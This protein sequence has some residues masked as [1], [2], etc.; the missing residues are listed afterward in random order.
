MI[1]IKRL[2][3]KALSMLLALVIIATTFFIFDPDLLRVESDAYANVET[4]QQ[5]TPLSAQT[6]YASETIYLKPGTNNFQYITNYDKNTGNVSSTLETTGQLYFKNDDA[7]EVA[8]AVNKLY[9]KG[10]DTNVAVNTLVMGSTTVAAYANATNATDSSIES[11]FNAATKIAT[12]SNGTMAYT[13]S[14]GSFSAHTDKTVDG[15]YFIEWIF[16]YKIDDIY[17]Y[18]FAYTGIYSTPLGMAGITYAVKKDDGSNNGEQDGMGFITGAMAYGGGNAKAAFTS[19]EVINVSGGI[20]S[21]TVFTNPLI[22]FNGY[23]GDNA[24][25]GNYTIPGNKDVSTAY[26]NTT[27]FPDKANGG[28]VRTS[29]R[30]YDGDVYYK[31]TGWSDYGSYA[32][33]TPEGSGNENLQNTNTTGVAYIVADISRF[34]NYN[35]LPYFKAGWA[36]FTY[37]YHGTGN[38]LSSMT[39]FDANAN[40]EV[41]GYSVNVNTGD[42]EDG[43]EDGKSFVRGLYA[44]NGAIPSSAT[45]YTLRINSHNG[46]KGMWTASVDAYLHVGFYTQPVNKRTIRQQYQGAL[47]SLCDYYNLINYAKITT[48]SYTSLFDSIKSAGEKICDPTATEVSADPT[49]QSNIKDYSDAIANSFGSDLYFYVPEAIYTRP[50]GSYGSNAVHS[51]ALFVNNVPTAN[52]P[53]QYTLQTG[54]V[55]Y[56]VVYF[57]YNDAQDIKVSYTIEESN[58][59]GDSSVTF[60]D[61]TGGSNSVTLYNASGSYSYGSS[62][63]T[64]YI[65]GCSVPLDGSETGCWIKW[66]VEYYDTMEGRSKNITARTYV[67]RT[68]YLPVAAGTEASAKNVSTWTYVGVQVWF[69][70]IHG[71]TSGTGGGDKRY[72][73]TNED[74]RFMPYS[75]SVSSLGSSFGDLYRYALSDFWQASSDN[76]YSPYDWSTDTADKEPAVYPSRFGTNFTVYDVEKTGAGTTRRSVTAHAISPTG[77]IAV[78][79]SRYTVGLSQIPGFSVGMHMT[80]NKRSDDGDWYLDDMT[81]KTLDGAGTWG[82][83]ENIRDSYWNNRGTQIVGGTRKNSCGVVYNGKAEGFFKFT[84]GSTTYQVKGILD[85]DNGNREPMSVASAQLNVTLYDKSALRTAVQYAISMGKDLDSKVF[86]TSHTQWTDYQDFLTAA[87]KA[88]TMVDGTY[89]YDQSGLNKLATDLTNAVNALLETEYYEDTNGDGTIGEG[90][91]TRW[92]SEARLWGTLTVKHVLYDP[93][94]PTLGTTALNAVQITDADGNVTSTT[95]VETK[96]YFYG[97]NIYSAYN[98]TPGYNYFGYY[99]SEEGKAW[100]YSSGS[101]PDLSILQ[102]DIAAQDTYGLSGSNTDQY[103]VGSSN[104]TYTYVYTAAES[105]LYL[106]LGD[107]DHAFQNAENLVRL[108]TATVYGIYDKPF[109]DDGTVGG[110][111]SVIVTD[112]TTDEFTFSTDIQGTNE[113]TP[114]GKMENK[115]TFDSGWHNVSTDKMWEVDTKRGSIRITDNTSTASADVNSVHKQLI[116]ITAGHK[117]IVTYDYYNHSSTSKIQTHIFLYNSTNTTSIK[118][119]S[120][121]TSSY[122]AFVGQ[123]SFPFSKGSVYTTTSAKSGTLIFEFTAPADY[124][125][126]A[127]R[128]GTS[129]SG[130]D[131]T[132]S[133]IQV[134]DMSDYVNHQKAEMNDI[135]F[136]NAATGLVP[137]K[138]YTVSFESPLTYDVRRWYYFDMDGNSIADASDITD[139][140]EWSHDQGTIQ[141]FI[142]TTS[143]GDDGWLTEYTVPVKV[144]TDLSSGGT[145][146]TFEMPAGCYNIN[147]GFCVT[148]NTPLSGTVTNVR[149]VEGDFVQ[150]GK[151]LQTVSIENGAGAVGEPTWMGYTF[152]GWTE[153][154]APFDGTLSSDISTHTHSFTYGIDSDTILANWEA[155]LYDVHFD[156]EIDVDQGIYFIQEGDSAELNTDTNTVTLTHSADTAYYKNSDAV[157]FKAGH[158]YRIS[159]DYNVT[160]GAITSLRFDLLEGVD[161]KKARYTFNTT[162]TS[163]TVSQTFTNTEGA[164]FDAELFIVSNASAG[165][166]VEFSDVYIQDITRNGFA[167]TT[168]S[169]PYLESDNSVIHTLNLSYRSTL[170][171]SYELG[172]TEDTKAVLPIMDSENFDFAGWYYDEAC[173]QAVSLDY[174]IPYTSTRFYSKWTTSAVFDTMGGSYRNSAKAPQDQTGLPLSGSSVK[175]A[176]YVPYKEGYNFAG[177]KAVSGD[178]SVNGNIYWPNDTVS[179]KCNVSFEAQW[180]AAEEIVFEGNYQFSTSYPGEVHYFSFNNPRKT[181]V[182]WA[183]YENST[184]VVNYYNIG[185]EQGTHEGYETNVTSYGLTYNV[186]GLGTYDAGQS[187]FGVAAYND[188]ETL[189]AIFTVRERF[190]NYSFDPAGGSLA[191]S[192]TVIGYVSADTTLPTPTR[193]GYTFTGWKNTSRDEVYTNN[194][195]PAE[196]NDAI[197]AGITATTSTNITLVAQWSINSYNM[198]AYAYSNKADTFYQSENSYSNNTVGGTVL[199]SNGEEGAVSTGENVFETNAVFTAT[200]ATGYEFKGW[201]TKLTTSEDGIVTLEDTDRVVDAGASYVRQVGAEDFTLYAKFSIKIY[202]W[203]ISAYHDT[204]ETPNSYVQGTIGGTALVGTADAPLESS[205]NAQAVHGEEITLYAKAQ[206]GYKFNGWYSTAA[207]V[208]SGSA[209]I[210]AGQCIQD[211]SGRYKYTITVDANKTY[212]AK[213]TVQKMTLTLNEN[214]DTTVNKGTY[215]QYAGSTVVLRNPTRTGHTLLGWTLV[216]DPSGDANG[217]FTDNGN[218]TITYTFGGGNDRI[219]A[220]WAISDYQVV[221]KP[222]GGT[223][224]A[225]SYQTAKGTMAPS[226]YTIN[227]VTEQ[228]TI[229]AA[230]QTAI[231]LQ[232]PTKAGYSFDGWE[233]TGNKGVFTVGDPAVYNVEA[234]DNSTVISAKWEVNSHPMYIQAYGNSASTDNYYVENVGGKVMFDG[235][236]LTTSTSDTVNYGD[237]RTI[238][239]VADTGYSFKGWTT[240]LPN[241]V[242][243]ANVVSS[244]ATYTTPGMGDGEITYYALF[245][246]NSYTVTATASYNSADADNV[247]VEGE[248]GGVVAG[249]GKVNY[250]SNAVL[251][252]AAKTGYDFVGWYS[253]LEGETAIYSSAT[254]SFAVTEDVTV[255]AKFAIKKYN[256]KAT[257]MANRVDDDTVYLE[258]NICGDISGQGDFYYGTTTTL[259]AAPRSGYEFLGWYSNVSLGE[260]AFITADYSVDVT[261]A[262][263]RVYNIWAKFAMLKFDVSISAA[264]VDNEDNITVSDIGGKVGFSIDTLT[265]TASSEYYTDATFRVY[266]Q[267]KV[268]YLLEGWYSD[269]TLETPA[270]GIHAGIGEAEGETG[271]YYQDFV[272]KG[273]V[274]NLYAKFK[275]STS[276]LN[277]IALSN[278]GADPTLYNTDNG[279]GTVEILEGTYTSNIVDRGAMITANVTYGMTATIRATAATGYTFEGWYS[280]PTFASGTLISDKGQ[281]E[282]PATVDAEHSYYAKFEIGRFIVTFDAMGG[283]LTNATADVYYGMELSLNGYTPTKTGFQFMGWDLSSTATSGYL[284]S[285]D[286]PTINSWYITNQGAEVTLYAIWSQQAYSIDLRTAYYDSAYNGY[287]FG[288]VG[289]TAKVI[290]AT[291]GVTTDDGTVLI[292]E[293]AGVSQFIEITPATGYKLEQWR[294]R[295]NPNGTDWPENPNIS[296]WSQ[297]LGETG[298]PACSIDVIV[299]F[300]LNDFDMEFYAYNNSAKAPTVFTNSATGGTVKIGENGSNGSKAEQHDVL[301]KNKVTAIATASAGYTFGGWYAYTTLDE[302]GAFTLDALTTP[303]ETG[304]SFTV[305]ADD[306]LSDVSRYNNNNYIAVFTINQYTATASVRTYVDGEDLVLTDPETYDDGGR[307]MN[308]GGNVGIGL[309]NVDEEMTWTE[310]VGG[311]EQS[312]TVYY[313]EKVYYKAKAETGY[314]FA[315]WYGTRGATYYGDNLVDEFNETYTRSQPARDT[316]LEAKFFP[317]TFTLRYDENGGAPGNP[318]EIR[319]TF[320][321]EFKYNESSNPTWTGHTFLGWADSPNGEVNSAYVG[322]IIADTISAWFVSEQ[323]QSTGMY[324]VYAV[325]EE[326]KVTVTLD[327]EKGDVATGDSKVDINQGDALPEIETPIY[328]GFVFGGYYTERGGQGEQRYDENGQSTYIWNTDDGTLYAY[329]K[330]PVLEDVE[331]NNGKWTYVYAADTGTY[332]VELSE[333]VTTRADI[334]AN[335]P[336]DAKWVSSIDTVNTSFIETQTER[337]EGINLNHYDQVALTN[338][339]NSVKD[340]DTQDELNTLNQPTVNQYVATMATSMDLDYADNR[341]SESVKPTVTI[342]ETSQKVNTIKSETD[343][344][345]QE[346]A[347]FQYEIPTS[348]DAASY[349]FAGKYSYTED[350]AVDYYIYTSSAN[351]VIA[352]EIGDGTVGTNASNNTAS[353]PTSATVTDN[354]AAFSYVENSGNAY[355]ESAVKATDDTSKAWFNAY[356]SAGIGTAHDYNAKTVI[357]LTPEFSSSGVRNEIVYTVKPSDDAYVVNEGIQENGA[358]LG[359]NAVSGFSSYSYSMTEDSEINIC[360]CY[361]NSMNG[362]SDEGT[363]D[364]S[365]DYMQMYIDQVDYDKYLNQMHL[366]RTSGGAS[367]WEL[368]SAG[369]SIYPVDDATYPYGTTGHILGSFMYV[370]DE[371]TNSVAASQAAA[372]NY[373]DAKNTIIQ[374]I[375]EDVVKAKSAIMSRNDSGNI[376]ST[377]TGLG[378]AQITGWSTNFYP[379]QGSYVY[380]HLVDRW[381]NV[382]NKVW[383]CN[384]VDPN[385]ST[386]SLD[387]EGAYKVL[388]TGGSNIDYITLDGANVTFNLD[389]TSTYE[390]GVLTTTGN[391]LTLSTGEANTTYNL[392]VVDNATNT[393][394]QAVTTDSNGMIVLNVEDSAI[395]VN[396]GAYTFTLNGETVNLYAGEPSVVR[397]ASVASAALVTDYITFTVKTA[398]DAIKVQVI[399][400]NSTWTYDINHSKINVVKNDDG[401]LT[402]TIPIKA[403]TVG[404]HVYSVRGKTAAGWEEVKFDNLI[405]KV[406]SDN[407]ASATALQSVNNVEVDAGERP[408]VKARTCVG[409]EKLQIVYADGSTITYNRTDDI[410]ISTI[411]GVETWLLSASAYSIPGSYEVSVVA[412]FEGQWQT[413]NTKTSTITVKAGDGAII[414]SVEG[415]SE[416]ARGKYTYFTV[417]TSAQTTKICFNFPTTTTTFT[418]SNSTVVE[419]ADGTKVWT[420]KVRFW[421]KGEQDVNFS[422]RTAAPGW[423]EGEVFGTITVK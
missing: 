6:V 243:D 141:L 144:T 381:G 267:A 313:R 254:Y 60:A 214:T 367:N 378:Y 399:E 131:V 46:Y 210:A 43:D 272:K 341:K 18:T 33:P 121:T 255:W 191:D 279:G 291:G 107:A 61:N 403:S 258:S 92:K 103:Y 355:V 98:E 89:G 27:L 236:A 405:C 52:D 88:L 53:S 101:T 408:T 274:E 198:T 153:D 398:G 219:T 225:I 269:P 125:G 263:P 340:T 348:A 174:K 353:Y 124:P 304:V 67:Y 62:G 47:T 93:T 297:G 369:E 123:D 316:Y 361:H 35:Q 200:P 70:G 268:G 2:S 192:S 140:E 10:S 404:E 235:G 17:H 57:S 79:S 184:R 305:A 364:G 169:D 127:L 106:D 318:T 76:D 240:T 163:G 415:D 212:I 377:G 78:D 11:K 111:S 280:D 315:G 59:A 366:F 172:K 325:W 323:V 86:N 91:A 371:T 176:N 410:V 394:T 242:A 138:T 160:S 73:K 419:N 276:V 228:T 171:D 155:N 15:V 74:K 281:A 413:Y 90:D 16:R 68:F 257:M 100:E 239:A 185:G 205:Y 229:S 253:S 391:V 397:N 259:T 370:F 186:M 173:T 182:F 51:S 7:T 339:L 329:W 349:V 8:V 285:I 108:D 422:A 94:Q 246:I 328:D 266:A 42:Y 290:E 23:A 45:M 217:S 388:E 317:E 335:A 105:G 389:S 50:Q 222:N 338:L 143:S 128:L 170:S 326:A 385:A 114:A 396:E 401:T 167:D 34:T 287:K 350:A 306:N 232:Q 320:N 298:M 37:H 25:S 5:A 177:W 157:T 95:S 309:T 299:F 376:N 231:S 218:D 83:D 324:T 193:T 120:L 32:D 292:P 319:V 202:T 81:G 233:V 293:G 337:A 40:N 296:S 347:N 64:K 390:N 179:F 31:T 161:T 234:D 44:I 39:V 9:K 249:G 58:Y 352:L 244:S 221:I 294:Y 21:N 277:V 307:P 336:D 112:N 1:K 188:E 130:D 71:F 400:G 357:Y 271:A 183:V 49:L 104:L 156:N 20:G 262:E 113:D 344:K 110:V 134:Y 245:N 118:A 362:T 139:F 333:R 84:N 197:L 359:G 421:S 310:S 363:A 334:T 164:D 122:N 420:V 303:L 135:F 152:Q 327:K 63:V 55:E 301:Y 30:V 147:L 166:V 215:E 402:W 102:G 133:N 374:N 284:Y 175:I 256:V 148:N 165:T 360:V 417:V 238:T 195:I 162:A 289:G 66:N 87:Q 126:M 187:Y 380:A 252:A 136:E 208:T 207:D 365:G 312:I 379:K 28:F 321:G 418:P 227:N 203:N 220:N 241:L 282:T 48:N 22:Q 26:S 13:Y 77:Y 331:Y 201:Y 213:F 224:G 354:A 72:S 115:F 346:N 75:Y 216:G 3:K 261:I 24:N 158:T 12:S 96:K 80:S 69:S 423:T 146:G 129:N 190:I 286:V 260:D 356:T 275:I 97:D 250:S 36:Q 416:A 308:T 65:T 204:A 226:T 248:T 56:G 270:V 295:Q 247:F 206:P 372:G 150:Y 251:T 168:V 178:T 142:S 181:R 314:Y 345:N 223:I 375:K 384:L 342:H 406:T 180:T 159:Y 368:P 154:D 132:F 14:S 322:R 411:D 278:N 288:E 237:T 264:S 41:S 194:T 332:P 4:V 196:T 414:Y 265:D 38:Y 54:E 392:T 358:S 387:S 109:E 189:S 386:I 117:Y 383:K 211:D 302:N 149:I 119:N 330:T 116:D 209:V 273:F 311:N 151:N 85:G 343:L 300:S 407:V 99:R 395:N 283:S 145:I 19:G 382:F 373:T 409:T 199:V 230:Y 351:P 412:K 29:S 82:D 137:G 393:T